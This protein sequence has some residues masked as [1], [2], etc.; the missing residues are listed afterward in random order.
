[1]RDFF[2]Q[3]WFWKNIKHKQE[4]LISIFTKL[5]QVLKMESNTSEDDTNYLDIL[6]DAI[7]H[8]NHINTSFPEH[9]RP[10]WTEIT[11]NSM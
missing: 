2:T 4:I 3:L 10:F 6:E 11:I 1:M 5:D 9:V 7:L 8:P